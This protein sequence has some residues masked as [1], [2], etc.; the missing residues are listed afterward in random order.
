MSISGTSDAA[1]EKPP[2]PGVVCVCDVCTY[3]GRGM[4]KCEL[5][6]IGN[7]PDVPEIESTSKEPQLTSANPGC[8]ALGSVRLHSPALTV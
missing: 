4:H 2:R 8:N 7:A 1:C 6:I 3:W 5:G